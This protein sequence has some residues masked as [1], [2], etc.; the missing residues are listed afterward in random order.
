LHIEEGRLPVNDLFTLLGIAAWKPLIGTLLLPPVPLLLLVL[1]GAR[2]ILVRRGLGWSVVLLSVALLWLAACAG[3]EALLRD[4]LLRPPPPLAS[5]R[6]AEWKTSPAARKDTAIV[7]LGGGVIR[8]AREYDA[9]TLSPISIER[10]R[11]GLW[12]ARETGLP[13]A[14]SGGIGWGGEPDGPTEAET[15]ARIARAEFGRPLQ[16]TETRSRDTRGNAVQSV[17]LLR[18]AGIRRIV[19]VT[20]AYHMPRALR[21][22]RAAAGEQITIEAAPTD[23][24]RTGPRHW[25]TLW[26]PSTAGAANVRRALHELVGLAAGA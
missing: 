18:E 12:L 21:A 20:H 24:S 4:H 26:L 7:V 9:A 5:A 23:V 10:L 25:T 1:L 11:Y 15:A 8:H 19:V 6:I 3:T 14:F 17:A 16:W 13:V 2:L 22:F